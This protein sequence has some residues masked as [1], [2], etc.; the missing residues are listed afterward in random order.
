MPSRLPDNKMISQIPIRFVNLEEESYHLF[1]DA[2]INSKTLNMLIDTGASKTIF[3]INRIKKFIRK[4]KEPFQT[5][6]CHS[7]G[8]GTNTMSSNI[9]KVKKFTI[10]NIVINDFNLILLDLSHVNQSYKM[11]ELQPIDGVLGSDLMMKYQAVID[12]KLLQL[13]LK[14]K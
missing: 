13:K 6:D 1:I 3:D 4:G 14:S 8:L 7:S 11:M 2:K 5:L 12:Y 10:G 9:T